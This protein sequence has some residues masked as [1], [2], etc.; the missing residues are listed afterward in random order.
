MCGIFGITGENTTAYSLSEM[1]NSL[2]HR[3]PDGY[4][5]WQKNNVGLGHARLA[6]LDTSQKGK[7]PFI[8]KDKKVIT[9]VN[10]EIYNYY[11]LRKKLEKL[12]A[13]FTSN[14]DSEIILHG[15]QILGKDLFQHLNGSINS[16]RSLICIC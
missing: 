7:Q 5:I 8:S 1:C 15:W 12:G 13:I 16:L 3:G 2:K 4:G 9:V 10:G 11:E 6:I 14:S